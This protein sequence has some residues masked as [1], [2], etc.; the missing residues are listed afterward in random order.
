M[1]QKKQSPKTFGFGSFIG[2][3][4]IKTL[5]FGLGLA[6]CGLIFGTLVVSSVWPNLP[7]LTAM[8]DYRPRIPL[9]IYSADKI[10]LAEYGEERRNV[11]RID[12]FPEVMKL[13]ILAAEDDNFYE[14]SGVDWRGVARAA[15]ANISS[16]GRAQG[17]STITMQVA[18]NFYLSTEKS[19]LRKFYELL[20][21]Y[22]IED[23]LTKDQ[24][25][26]LYMNQIYLGHRSYGFSVAARTY[27]AKPLSEV[28]LAE[29]AVLAGIPKAPSQNNPRT[30]LKGA[31]DRQ[32]YVLS[33][34]LR[35]GY[36]DQ[37]QFDAAK[38]EE[39]ATR[40]I[41]D[42]ETEEAAQITQAQR[43]GHYVA[44]LARQLM[45]LTYKDNVYARGLN[46]YTTID[47]KDQAVAYRALRKNIMQFTRNRPYPGPEGQI[48]LPEGVENDNKAMEKIIYDVRQT[49]PNDD[50][51]LVAVVLS[52][53]A[54]KVTLMRRVG[55]VIE[56]T[57]KEL[58]NARRAL[59]PK[60]NNA[61]PILR[62]SI[63]YIQRFE[64][65]GW[66]I[67]NQPAVEGAFV[68]L[69]PNTGAIQSMVGGFNF[70]RGDFNRVTQA[71]RQPGSTFKPFI[72]AA[73]LERGL[74]PETHIS[75][76]PFVLTARQ[77]G[78]KP[79]QPKNY[80]GSYT[81]SQTMRR[82]LYQSRNMV[83]IRILE[84]VGADFARAYITRFGFDIRRQPQKGAYLTMALGAGSVTPLQMAGAYA[85]FA[86]GGFRVNPYIID[87][88]LDPEGNEIMRAQPQKAGVESNRVLDERTAY[89]M[90]DLLHGVATSG[91][92]ARTTSTLG[93]KDLH[94]KTGTT[95]QAFDAW[96][97]GYTKDLVGV[98]WMG[99][100]QPRSL[101][102]NATG[103]Q[104]AMPIW[105]E[106]MQTALKGTEV[107]MPGPLPKG[108]TKVGENFYYEEFPQGK[109]FANLGTS[110]AGAG[111]S[112]GATTG[113]GQRFRPI[114]PRR[115]P[116][117]RTIESFNP[118][119]GAPIRF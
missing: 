111:S 51:L 10:L 91:T 41:R 40:S 92:A 105:I 80:G 29:A 22:K 75:D 118:T 59:P 72:Y 39:I 82:A 94:G 93:R 36:I 7:N 52:S 106:Y 79:W 86:N 56:L 13:A 76:Q 44:E 24:I 55:E 57:G 97:A 112:S 64:K 107:K 58:N 108:L 99:Y 109:A 62:G 35:L 70:N 54:D 66:T 42:L 103:G 90:N 73:G 15:L 74:T 3:F 100:D 21:T 34:M 8:T 61:K 78:S 83:S 6:V 113:G 43:Q 37:A 31:L 115:N 60:P 33:R 114:Q 117:Q 88:V 32:H 25:L 96:F 20:L 23:N 98:A 17:A 49:H 53:S 68:A 30:N 71:W 9:R 16:G 5:F 85:V 4:L 102:S 47:S 67:V 89:V 110:G 48:D 26:E 28:T 81:V 12:E 84:A 19:Y 104:L 101:G 50:D 1:S 2:R 45:Y 38:A 11:L 77:T 18:R 27:F 119:G 63:V 95:N 65:D 46:V 116:V 69:D 87:Y 14:H